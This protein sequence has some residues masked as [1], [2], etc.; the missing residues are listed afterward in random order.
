MTGL[1]AAGLAGLAIPLQGSDMVVL[2]VVGMCSSLGAVVRA[3]VTGILIIFEMTHQFSLVLPL[4][5]GALVSQSIAKRLL[6]SSFYEAVL[7][8]DGHHL[9]RLIPPRDLESWHQLPA[10]TVA[11]FQPASLPDLSPTTLRNALA[12]HPYSAFPLTHE[13]G[14]TGVVTRKAMEDALQHDTPPFVIPAV[15]IQPQETIGSIQAHFLR[16]SVPLIVLCDE[17]Q[18]LLGLV[19]PHDLLRAQLAYGST[20]GT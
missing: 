6:K 19:T 14:V 20:L 18:A 8:Q 12:S 17:R 11:N 5:L 3:P 2:A 1:A 15:T 4:M 16:A 13:G 9:Q 10:S 7:E